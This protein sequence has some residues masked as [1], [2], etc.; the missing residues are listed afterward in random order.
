[1]AHDGGIT[2]KSRARE[3]RLWSIWKSHYAFIFG[4]KH[5][6]SC[7]NRREIRKRS[8]PCWTVRRRGSGRNRP[9]RCR[10]IEAV[11]EDSFYTPLLK[12]QTWF[13]HPGLAGL[14]AGKTVL[15]TSGEP[16]RRDGKLVGDIPANT[17]DIVLKKYGLLDHPNVKVLVL[18]VRPL[19][20][21]QV[22]ECLERPGMWSPYPVGVPSDDSVMD[23]LTLLNFNTFRRLPPFVTVWLYGL[24]KSRECLPG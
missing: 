12:K 5:G 7:R 21:E 15:L 16:F 2:G 9:V 6:Q 23:L 3:R 19:N 18:S 13:S 4:K 14:P 17:L 20:K 22:K 1:M 11:Q 8:S 10:E 24:E